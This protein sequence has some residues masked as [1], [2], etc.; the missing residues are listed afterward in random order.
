[1]GNTPFFFSSRIR[2]ARGQIVH[3]S[4]V[5]GQKQDKVS[6]TGSLLRQLN[7]RSSLIDAFFLHYYSMEMREFI[8]LN[9]ANSL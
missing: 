3:A 9:K 4:F 6:D 7:N 5:I 8:Y 2:Q 1:M